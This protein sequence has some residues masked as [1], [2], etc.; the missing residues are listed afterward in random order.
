MVCKP[1]DHTQAASLTS[2]AAPLIV[3]TCESDMC[4]GLVLDSSTSWHLR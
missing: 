2:V 4:R 1:P 3:S